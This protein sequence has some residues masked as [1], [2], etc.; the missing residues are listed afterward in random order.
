MTFV[1]T[2]RSS[3][4][5]LVEPLSCAGPI[6][7]Q[8]TRS[9]KTSKAILGSPV[10]GRKGRRSRPALHSQHYL[11]KDPLFHTLFYSGFH[12][13]KWSHTTPA[14]AVHV[15]SCEWVFVFVYVC[16]IDMCLKVKEKRTLTI[17]YWNFKFPLQL[18]L[19]ENSIVRQMFQTVHSPKKNQ[20]LEVPGIHVFPSWWFKESKVK[21][22]ILGYS[23]IA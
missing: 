1:G 10:P 22:D 21:Q 9:K 8:S 11:T 13:T 2:L 17:W 20:S 6:R 15:W 7:F 4:W 3:L 16:F 5:I 23:G 19:K 18:I 14:P 12:M